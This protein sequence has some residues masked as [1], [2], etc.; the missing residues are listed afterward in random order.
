MYKKAIIFFSFII[1]NQLLIAETEPGIDTLMVDK[2]SERML[3]ADDPILIQLDSLIN[4]KY[5]NR[6]QPIYQYSID[7]PF[8]FDVEDLPYYADSVVAAKLGMLD[9]T[10]PFELVYN[11]QVQR[12]IDFWAYRRRPLVSNMLGMGRLYFPLFEE[13][14]DKYDLPIELKYL[15]IVESALNPVAV[16]RAGAVGLWQFMPATGRIYGLSPGRNM[17]ERSDPYL[18][19]DA[20]CRHFIDLYNRFG[21]WNLVLAAYNCGSGCVGRAIRRAGGETDFW[22]LQPFLPRET[23]NYVPAFI[24]ITYVMKHHKDYNLFPVDPPFDFYELDTVHVRRIITLDYLAEQLDIGLEQ[25]RLLNPAFKNGI[26]YAAPDNPRPLSIPRSLVGFFLANLDVFYEEMSEIAENNPAVA[27]AAR[28]S[29]HSG[30]VHVVRRGESLS[31]IARRY[32][33]TVSALKH[34]NNLRS[35]M[36]HPGQRLY[37]P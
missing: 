1:C 22:R 10:T 37:I 14:L 24:A 2:A 33:S 6:N 25:L 3:F 32:G 36:I 28:S 7:N 31:V 12:F 34:E 13:M 15:A 16:S 11:D 20:A 19:T 23:Q 21:C 29:S 30:T 8:G 18:S 35:N 26:V 17:D 5:F 27:A 9:I 4:V